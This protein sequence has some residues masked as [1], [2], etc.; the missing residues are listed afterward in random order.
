MSDALYSV[1]R[2][3]S[4][5]IDEL[6]DAWVTPAKLQVWYCPTDL[7]V[8][9]GSVISEAVVDGWWTVGV[10]V[11]Q[12]DFVAYFYG[13][14]LEVSVNSKLVHTLYYTQDALEFQARD[15]TKE[16]HTIHI[17]FAERGDS[18]WVR[19]TQFGEMPAEQ[20]AQSKAGM[21]SYFDNLQ[22]FL[23]L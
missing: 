6:W 18:S 23:A 19:F 7:S 5:S 14:Y 1:E 9:L 11:P 13:K 2:E 22:K 16:F 10:E 21:E 12:F 15:L 4:V 3:F 20:A 17:D 8:Q